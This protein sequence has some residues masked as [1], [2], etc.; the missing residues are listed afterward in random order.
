MRDAGAGGRRRSTM[1]RILV[2]DDH[3]QI[4]RLVQLEL[5]REGH[6]VLAAGDGEEALRVIRQQRPALVV[7]DINLPV[8]DGLEVLREVRSDPELQETPVILLTVLDHAVEVTHGLAQGADW[9]VTKPFAPGDVATLVRRFLGADAA[10][11]V[12]AAAP[13]RA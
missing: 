8:K 12:V 7:L 13:V 4:V 3:P 11:P 5:E 9:Y 10:R 2:V 6:A 1:A